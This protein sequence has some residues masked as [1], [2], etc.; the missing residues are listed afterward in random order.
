MLL[1][2]LGSLEGL[3]SQAIWSQAGGESGGGSAGGALPAFS[4]F[5]QPAVTAAG[6]YLMMLPQTLEG[7][8]GADS[9]AEEEVVDAEW[10]DR[11]S[12]PS[13]SLTFPVPCNPARILIVPDCCGVDEHRGS[14]SDR[15]RWSPVQVQEWW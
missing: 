10:L 12:S 5:P 1:Q 8:L 6:E 2:V 14:T 4:A 7:L 13:F 11:V 15:S 3:G 9:D